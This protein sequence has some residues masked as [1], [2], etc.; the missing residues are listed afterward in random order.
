MTQRENSRIEIIQ[1]DITRISADAVVNAAN[2]ELAMGGGVCGAIFRAAGVEELTRACKAI[3]HCPTGGAVITPAFGMSNARHIIHAVGPVYSRYAPDEARTLLRSAYRSAIVLAVEHDCTGIAFPAIGTGI[4]GYPLEEACAE[5]VDV[6]LRETAV[7][8][9]AVKLVAFDEPAPRAFAKRLPRRFEVI[10]VRPAE[11]VGDL[12]AP[13]LIFHHS[14]LND[15]QKFVRF[16]KPNVP[17][18]GL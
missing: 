10:L 15:I 18:G 7:A 11:T 12:S 8:E 6:C 2:S 17:C 16:I 4:Y 13:M 9:I 3:G 1:G 14:S 5:A